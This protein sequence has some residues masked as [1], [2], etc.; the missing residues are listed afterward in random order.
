MARPIRSCAGDLIEVVTMNGI[1]IVSTLEAM[2]VRC[3]LIVDGRQHQHA[4]SS[5]ERISF[6]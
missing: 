2:E 4:W 3:V 1:G 5:R 6:D